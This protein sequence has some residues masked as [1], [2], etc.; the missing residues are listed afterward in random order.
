MRIKVKASQGGGMFGGG[1]SSEVV[2]EGS[3][4]DA[5]QGTISAM[6]I[7][8]QNGIGEYPG[9]DEET[10]DDSPEEGYT[11]P[12]D[13]P[14]AGW[15]EDDPSANWEAGDESPSTEEHGSNPGD[16]VRIVWNGDQSS[17]LFIDSGVCWVSPAVAGLYSEPMTVEYNASDI[18]VYVVAEVQK[19]VG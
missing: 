16:A 13:V 4:A 11:E 14:A 6:M 10:D 5:A 1:P 3:E 18:A 19:H 17:R 12:D 8:A 2:I 9:D 7:L 15:K